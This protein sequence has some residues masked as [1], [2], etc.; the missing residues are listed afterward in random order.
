MRPYNDEQQPRRWGSNR[1]IIILLGIVLGV[2]MMNAVSHWTT[3]GGDLQT[4]SGSSKNQAADS[5]KP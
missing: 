1:F 2:A 4:P 5:P 3:G